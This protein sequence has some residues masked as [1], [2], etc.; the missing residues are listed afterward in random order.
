MEHR[1]QLSDSNT[2]QDFLCRL[3]AKR[4]ACERLIGAAVASGVDT[5]VSENVQGNVKRLSNVIQHLI[6]DVERQLQSVDSTFYSSSIFSETLVHRNGSVGR[7]K[8]VINLTQIDYLRSWQF[9]R[10]RIC[11]ALT[12]KY[13]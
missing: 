10:T 4:T 13:R 1:I 11:H 6:D 12:L 2:L 8:L 7:P 9:T 5:S 3:Q